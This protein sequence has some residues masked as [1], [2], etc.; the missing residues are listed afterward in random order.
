LAVRVEEDPIARALDER[1]RTPRGD[2]VIE[3]FELLR[4]EPGAAGA[5]VDRLLPSLA[6][7]REAAAARVA[8]V[9]GAAYLVKRD[10]ARARELL[11]EGLDLLGG[12]APALAARGAL[13]LA[14]AELALGNAAAARSLVARSLP[15]LLDIAGDDAPLQEVAEC[16]RGV[17]DDTAASLADRLR[18]ERRARRDDGSGG[19]LEVVA[20]LARALNSS[21]ATTAEPLYAILRA[22][23]AETGAERGSLLL[24]DGAALRFEVGLGRDGRILG[25]HDFALSTT[26]VERALETG[27]AVVVPDIAATLP[28][29]LASSAKDL[30]LR[31][32][33]CAPLRVERKRPGATRGAQLA[34]V[35]GT[36]GV[37]YVDATSEGS[38]GEEDARFFEVLADCA[39]LA[40]RTART[41]AELE[42]ATAGARQGVTA[43]PS[44]D[45]GA[46]GARGVIEPDPSAGE[47]PDAAVLARTPE[48][49][50]RDAGMIALLRTVERA[51]ASDANVLIRGESGT[52]KELIARAL[53]RQG[54]RAKGPFVVI[55]CGAVPDDLV[56]S[57]LFGHEA[58]AFTG[59]S[60]ARGGLLERANGGTLFLDEVGEMS[61]TMQAALLRAVQEGEV[62]RL[63]ADAPRPISVR[64]V[65]A[66]HRDLRAMVERGELRQD[67]LFRLAVVELRIPPLRERAGDVPLLARSILEKAGGGATIDAAAL[68]RLEEHGWPGNVRE[69]ENVLSAASVIGR[70][71]ITLAE[72]DHV[73]GEATVSIAPRRGGEAPTGDA[74]ARSGTGTLE[75]LEKE[76][77]LG[78]LERHGWNQVQAAKSLGLDRNTLRRKILR[79]GIVRGRV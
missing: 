37:L 5:L 30:G 16:L 64:L 44:R 58:S 7:A 48:L 79:Y 68:E 32:A 54:P 51:A 11:L 15:S 17:H 28:F 66:T 4:A 6:K 60:E 35:R 22:I 73:L 43:R 49:V 78:R 10:A 31:S 45:G 70:G 52:G 3:A 8:L 39:L 56:A 69:L 13:R 46:R 14:A 2:A 57:E 1:G 72:V 29:A 41:S 20:R 21:V 23:L 38:F 50:T 33:L 47:S 59:A 42:R 24:Y 71:V 74:R 53:H 62:R 76:T 67:L 25:A 9:L 65:A 77:I 18:R 75:E 63:G 55:D 26:I 40:L 12:T 36:A 27:Q 34:S 61:P 19:R